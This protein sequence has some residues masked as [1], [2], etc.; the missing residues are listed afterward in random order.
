LGA[1]QIRFF[2]AL[3]IGLIIIVSLAVVGN[4][5]TR[6]RL[7][8]NMIKPV[9]QILAPDLLRSVETP[10]YSFHENGTTKFTVRAKKLLE[11]KQGKSLLQGI[12]AEDYNPDSSL[13]NQIT[14][15]TAEYDKEQKQVL[16]YGDVRLHLGKDVEI[17]MESL[18]YNMGEQTGTSDD[19][20]RYQ[21]PQATGTATGVRYD[22]AKR[23]IE[24][25][26]DLSFLVHR[27][28]DPAHNSGKTED[29]RLL[30]QHGFYSEQEHL[31]RLEGQARVISDS[32][33]LSGE[34]IDA[35]F[36]PD[37]RHLTSLSSH[38]EAMYES[39]DPEETRTLRGDHLDF[40]IGEES[41]A[42]ESIH[43]QGQAGFTLKSPN[44]EQKLTAEEIN[45]TLDPVQGRPLAMQ[46]QRGVH[47]G[48]V[49]GEQS[50]EISGEWL[51]ASF[52]VGSNNLKSMMVKNQARMKFNV[53][54]VAPDELQAETIILTFRNQEGRS[55][56]REMQAEK[57]VIWKSPGRSAAEPGRSLTSNTLVMRYS[58]SGEYLESGTAGGNVVLTGLPRPGSAG[59]QLQQLECNRADFYF[60]PVNNRLQRMTGEGG[61]RVNTRSATS[62]SQPKAEEF[63]TSSNTIEVRFRASDGAVE[64]MNQSGAFTY[65]DGTRSAASDACDFSSATE[66]LI[67]R[68]HPSLKEAE[69]TASGEVIE[70]DRKMKILTIRENVRSV[71]LSAAG[72]TQGFMTSSSG[73]PSP[74][75][76]TA[77]EMVYT[78]EK[79]QT[80]YSGKVILLSAENHLQAQRLTILNGG[81]RVEAEGEVR[82]R[83]LEFGEP[84]PG[85]PAKAAPPAIVK[86]ATGPKRS[87]PVLIRCESLLY[88]RTTGVIHYERNV[89]LDSADAKLWADSM[90][91]F[92]DSDGK[93]VERAKAL[94]H[95]RITQPGRE[96]K[97]QEGEYFLSEGKFVVIGSP[98]SPAEITDRVKG[99]STAPRLTFYIADDRIEASGKLGLSYRNIMT[100]Y[101]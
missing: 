82:H 27:T 58:A 94:G 100:Y 61:V 53:S 30:A 96:V 40:N 18:R 49:R 17:R 89:S 77:D 63:S 72:R 12:S 32:G 76:V 33:T 43:A 25:L 11:T 1:L 90:D 15:Q 68:G 74:T 70:Y 92:L 9:A 95:L 35:A 19:P 46:S 65:E 44:G 16:F 81:E 98:G 31:V 41:Q 47:F 29:Y 73:N 7:R 39:K 38:G 78:K 57:G 45:L 62:P 24:L 64:S 54:S 84:L 14:S 52:V 55:F 10:E 13:R 69:Y 37:K 59:A 3:L 50:S 99:K 8:R 91:I 66:K 20:I 101:D 75:V 28:A 26:S 6:Q 86:K 21:A 4:Y 34:R 97:G 88:S 48:L 36:T 85:K 56:P 83:I 5:Y 67:L 23:N 80:R 51:E 87:G 79:E 93:R 22:N 60:Y 2:R 71:L 42:L